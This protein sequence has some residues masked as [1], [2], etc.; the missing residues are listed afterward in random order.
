MARP[1]THP[2]TVL[3]DHRE[4]RSATV[5]LLD[6]SDD[7]HMDRAFVFERKRLADFAVSIQDGRLFR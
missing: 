5:P 3:A 2:I 7:Y 1:R 4:A 6:S